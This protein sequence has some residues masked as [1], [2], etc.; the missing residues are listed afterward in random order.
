MF[1]PPTPRQ[2]PV[3]TAKVVAIAPPRTGLVIDIA[4]TAARTRASVAVLQTSGKI[5]SVLKSP[6]HSALTALRSWQVKSS[7]SGHESGQVFV[8]ELKAIARR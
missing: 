6:G 3:A 4:K 8:A 1:T 7:A 2:T 5:T